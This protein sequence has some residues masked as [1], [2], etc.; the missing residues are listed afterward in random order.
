MLNYPTYI[1]FFPHLCDT[2]FQDLR[3][4]QE[5]RFQ[6]P[7]FGSEVLPLLTVDLSIQSSDLVPPLTTWG[8]DRVGHMESLHCTNVPQILGSL[9]SSEHLQGYY[10]LF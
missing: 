8:R 9:N 6:I 7:T 10:Q 2:V 1:Y 5:T 4:T 3:C